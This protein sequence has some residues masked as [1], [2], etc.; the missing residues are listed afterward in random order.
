MGRSLVIGDNI[1]GQQRSIEPQREEEKRY[2][3][4]VFIKNEGKTVSLGSFFCS[5]IN[6]LTALVMQNTAIRS[7]QAYRLR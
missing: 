5:N 1:L 4:K 7:S 3:D 6:P 2:M